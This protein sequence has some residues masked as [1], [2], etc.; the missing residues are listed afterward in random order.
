MVVEA[1]FADGDDLG[2]IGKALHVG[3]VRGG[4][5]ARFVRVD[6]Y[7]RVDPWVLLSEGDRATDVVGAVSVANSEECANAGIISALDCGV[8][9]RRELRTIEVSV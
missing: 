2:V 4:E 9:I 3:E 1:D 7:G 8:A 6:A 5:Q